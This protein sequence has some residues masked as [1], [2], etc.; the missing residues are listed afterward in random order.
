VLAPQ[1]ASVLSAFGAATA[2]V[3][4]ERSQ[5]FSMLMPTDETQLLDKAQ[6]LSRAVKA[7]LS[8]D[9]IP[10]DQQ[11]IQLECDLHFLRQQF[12]LTM[13]VPDGLGNAAQN[14]L[15]ERF[16]AEY[17]QRYG[18]GALVAGT[19]IEVVGLRAIGEGS[20]VRATL[21]RSETAQ[22]HPAI[23]NGARGIHLEKAAGE[24]AFV[25]VATFDV[26]TLEPGQ[27]LAGPALIDAR[28]TTIWIPNGMSASLDAHRTLNI[29]VLQ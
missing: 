28:D 29:E 24:I 2:N 22:A 23:A 4:R 13:A 6:I 12:E 19:P 5:A 27:F 3:R 1:L 26:D 25:Q 14:H 18:A 16:K 8:A 17:A 21:A 7:D 9:G 15:M 20:T 10:E 11:S